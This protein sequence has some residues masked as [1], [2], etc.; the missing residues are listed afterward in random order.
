MRTYPQRAVPGVLYGRNTH[1]VI[2]R[3]RKAAEIKSENSRNKVLTEENQGSIMKNNS[4]KQRVAFR[5]DVPKR[6]KGSHSKC[7][8]SV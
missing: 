6:L 1:T 5:G 2:D 7:D 3:S 4:Y 8:R